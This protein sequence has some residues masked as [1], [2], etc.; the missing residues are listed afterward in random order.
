MWEARAMIDI[1]ERLEAHMGKAEIPD[2]L[3]DCREAANE[4]RKLRFRLEYMES[5]YGQIDWDAAF[6][7][8]SSN[9]VENTEP[10]A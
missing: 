8:A 7:P 5:K 4:I 2:V 6:P 1:V 10:G 3:P 9:L